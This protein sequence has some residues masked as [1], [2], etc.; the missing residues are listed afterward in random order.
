[1]G[2]LALGIYSYGLSHKKEM[3]YLRWNRGLSKQTTRPYLREEGIFSF[4]LEMDV[5]TRTSSA[6]PVQS[7]SLGGGAAGGVFCGIIGLS[8]SSW[9][10]LKTRGD[11][12]R[13]SDGMGWDGM[14]WMDDR[15]RLP[16][17]LGARSAFPPHV[18]IA[19]SSTFLARPTDRHNIGAD[20][21]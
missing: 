3:G 21:D 16:A 19:S 13:L 5:I 10:S 8:A 2:I 15:G 14:G 20:S 4:R 11:R 1:M 12:R 9:F 7:R 6:A 18:R 17:C